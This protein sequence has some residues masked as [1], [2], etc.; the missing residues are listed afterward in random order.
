MVSELDIVCFTRY[1]ERWLC[2]WIFH[3][4]WKQKFLEGF[5]GV[6]KVLCMRS[7]FIR[8]IGNL[9]PMLVSLN[10]CTPKVL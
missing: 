9:A 4:I 1:L 10:T 7:I 8:F 5:Y 6:R 2:V 3:L